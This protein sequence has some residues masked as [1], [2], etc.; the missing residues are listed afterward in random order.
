MDQLMVDASLAPQV[1]VGDEAILIGSQ[2][3]ETL[4][5]E[6]V[7]RLAGTVGYEV[8]THRSNRVPRIYVG[9]TP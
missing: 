2:G 4:D 9:G 6:E 3:Q 8:L 7:G 1:A 5:A